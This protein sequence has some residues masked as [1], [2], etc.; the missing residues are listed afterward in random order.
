MEV[1]KTQITM[2]LL[3]DLNFTIKFKASYAVIRAN[4]L[5]YYISL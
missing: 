4:L 1:V 5:I 2:L 3:K